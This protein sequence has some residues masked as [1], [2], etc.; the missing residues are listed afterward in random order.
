MPPIARLLLFLL[1][2]AATGTAS[3]DDRVLRFNNLTDTTIIRLYISPSGAQDWGEDLLASGM[4]RLQLPA[5]NQSAVRR[6]SRPARFG[7]AS[8]R[9]RAGEGERPATPAD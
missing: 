3:A 8:A 7:S 2:S 5:L 1:A 9:R 4:R 6:W